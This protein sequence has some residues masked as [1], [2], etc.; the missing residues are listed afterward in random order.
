MRKGGSCLTLDGLESFI[1]CDEEKTSVLQR[2]KKDKNQSDSLFKV[3]FSSCVISSPSLTAVNAFSNV[4]HAKTAK[5]GNNYCVTWVS[6][7]AVSMH[8]KIEHL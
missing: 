8:F 5:E 4:K 7:E 6:L 3:Y 2:K 1:L